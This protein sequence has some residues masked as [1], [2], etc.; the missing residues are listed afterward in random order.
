MQG[1]WILEWAMALK[2]G[3]FKKPGFSVLSTSLI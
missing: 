2:P 1:F 3:F